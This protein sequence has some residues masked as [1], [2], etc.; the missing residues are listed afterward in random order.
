MSSWFGG[1]HGNNRNS[2]NDNDNDNQSST[3]T[4]NPTNYRLKVTAGSEYDVKTHQLVPVNADETLRIE[5]EHAV[6]HLCVRIRDYTGLPNGSPATNKYFSHPLHQNDQYSICFS[7]TPKHDINGNNLVFGNDFSRPIRDSIPPG[8]STALRIVKWAIDPAL[9]GD[10]YADKP[11]LYSPG[12]A[13]WNYFRIGD[14][15]QHS[16]N[17]H[18]E[19]SSMNVHDLVVE[20]GADGSGEQTRSEKFQ[21]PSD[22]AQRRK[23]FLDEN[24]RQEF[25]FEKDR[26]YLVD[27]GNPYLGF[28]GDSYIFLS[29]FLIPVSNKANAADCPRKTD[30]TL[31]LPGF[32]LH[33]AEYIDAKK[34][35][36]RYTLKD[37]KTDQTY[38]VVLLTLLVRGSEEEV[39]ERD[40]SSSERGSSRESSLERDDKHGHSHQEGRQGD[41]D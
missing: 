19:T 33:V 25:I 15:V 27:F 4:H 39:R 31:R 1:S 38:L 21:I 6:I 20:E 3:S 37:R 10:P 9:D 18:K 12:L 23:H 35:K 32:H 2:N 13:S 14:K 24:I 11:Y 22:S 16:D 5:S 26:Q 40:D 29:S 36:L 30:F 34:H 8:F 28:N 17:K 41:V 7:F